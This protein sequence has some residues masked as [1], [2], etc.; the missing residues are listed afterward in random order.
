[1]GV[2]RERDSPSRSTKARARRRG[3]GD[4]SAIESPSVSPSFP[5]H[6][7]VRDATVAGLTALLWAADFA[8]RPTDGAL[9]VAVGVA[10]GLFTALTGFLAHEYGHLAASLATGARVSYPRSALSTLL[11]HFDS[12]QNDRRQ[13]FA[14]SFGG[15]GATLVAVGAI[16]ALAPLDAWSGRVALGLAG[17]GTLVTFALEVPI[18]VRVWRGAPLPSGVAYRPYE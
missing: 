18:T 4:A 11:F 5:R 17:A 9:P 10:T 6:L 7:A 8:L 14:M 16:A 3:H 12:A 1:M 13:F 15:Y 2:A